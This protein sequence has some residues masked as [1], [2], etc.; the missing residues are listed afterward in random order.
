MKQAISGVAPSESGEVTSMTVWPTI[1]SLRT[2]PFGRLG[3]T[4]GRLYGIRWG[5]GRIFTV[6]NI[7]ALLSIPSRCSCSRTA[8]HHSF[9]EDIV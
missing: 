4:L 2:P 9:A 3:C 8:C 6:G 7:I 1:T 5:L